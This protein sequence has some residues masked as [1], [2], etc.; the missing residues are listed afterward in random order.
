MATPQTGI[1]AQGTRVH[2]HL[3]FDLRSGVEPA[4]VLATLSPLRQP[5]VT[6]GGA[7]IVI[8]FGPA[9]WRQI[10]P[11]AVP[12]ALGPFPDVEGVPVVPHDIWVWIHGTGEDV[13]LDLARA[14]AFVLAPIAD[15]VTEIAGFV[16]HDSR[17][18]TGFIDGTENPP[19]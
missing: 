1:F 8:G 6:A 9:L 19:L 17:D 15:L 11:Q 7:N 4:R 14:V 2:H 5:S 3:E 18:L 12:A 13:M 10:A 16:Y